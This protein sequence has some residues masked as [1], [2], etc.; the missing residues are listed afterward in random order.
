MV[1][2]P[3]SVRRPIGVDIARARVVLSAARIR[4][5]SA[6]RRLPA[7]PGDER[8]SFLS[9]TLRRLAIAGCIVAAGAIS[10]PAEPESE[11][12]AILQL[13]VDQIRDGTAVTIGGETIAS[14]VVLPEFYERRGFRPAWTDGAARADLLAA[15]RES[16]AD[17]LDPRDYHVDAIAALIRGTPGAQSDADLDLLA[18][19]AVIRLAYHLRFGKVDLATVEPDW[20]FTPEAETEFQEPPEAAL[21]HAVEERRVPAALDALRP[22]HWIYPALK[23]ALEQ[24][25]ALAAAGGW[26]SLPDGPAPKPGAADPRLAALERRLAVE[27][28]LESPPRASVAAYDS[29]LIRAMKRFQER[30]GLNPDGVIG[31]TTLRALNVPVQT[32][33]DQLRIS[34]ERSRLLLHDLPQRFVLVNI[35]AFRVLYVDGDRARLVSRVVVGKPF[36][37]TPIFRADMTY[38]VLNPSW[39]IPPGIMKRDVIPGMKKDPGY[40]EKKGYVKVGNQIVQPPGPDNALG[41]IKL[42]FPNPHHVY[43]HDTPHLDK[44]AF[45]ERTFSNGCIRVENVVDLAALALDDPKWTKEKLE[46]EIATGKTRNLTLA[47]KL[48]VLLTYWTAVIDPGTARPRFFDDAYGRDPEFLAAL[49]QPFRF[50]HRATPTGMTVP[51]LSESTLAAARAA[52]GALERAPRAAYAPGGFTR[53]PP[54]GVRGPGGSFGITTAFASR[55]ALYTG[56]MISTPARAKASWISSWSR[57]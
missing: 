23:K 51:G 6:I 38:L 52:P 46:Q 42:M 50:R 17:G 40:L 4:R 57:E 53:N 16:A 45:D 15:L 12:A 19:D 21:E 33:I 43:L 56:D 35:P 24:Y 32:R 3:R 27:G 7:V 5:G 41:R 29:V 11:P 1:S 30:H 2:A 9:V 10:A 54:G 14:T 47:R 49:D 25:R 55:S 28:D 26:Q 20:A 34:L 22:T 48:P 37:Q 8:R 18:T 13:R 39:T 31:K 44:F 36:T